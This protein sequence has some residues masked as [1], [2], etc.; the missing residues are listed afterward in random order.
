[1]SA[2][3]STSDASSESGGS[4]AVKAQ[5][6]QLEEHLDKFGESLPAEIRD[7]FEALKSRLG[8]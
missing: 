2:V 4:Q 8:A 1:M 5:L 6:P 3:A 7:Q